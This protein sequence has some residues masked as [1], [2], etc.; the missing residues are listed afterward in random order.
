MRFV[1]SCL[2]Y[3]IGFIA[4]FYIPLSMAVMLVHARLNPDINHSVGVCREW[5]YPYIGVIVPE[6]RID[7]LD[8]LSHSLGSKCSC[9]SRPR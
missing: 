4:M 6:Q 5:C 9:A 7:R 2:F 1:F 3:L 8:N